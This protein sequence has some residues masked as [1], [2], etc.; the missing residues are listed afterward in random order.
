MCNFLHNPHISDTI[1]ILLQPG[2]I[3][4]SF[5]GFSLDLNSRQATSIVGKPARKSVD[6]PQGSALAMKRNSPDNEL[7][8][9][10]A[11][12]YYHRN[13]KL[14]TNERAIK[15]ALI[16]SCFMTFFDYLSIAA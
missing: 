4:Q 9:V 6:S 15:H 1:F 13:G 2:S 3:G 5:G 12:V 11:T 8:I 14:C 7:Y 16:H 10:L